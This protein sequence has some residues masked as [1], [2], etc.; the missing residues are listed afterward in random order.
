MNAARFRSLA[1]GDLK[2]QSYHREPPSGI[3]VGGYQEVEAETQDDQ[4][5][6]NGHEFH[7]LMFDHFSAVG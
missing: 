2:G 3:E 7:V 1:G 6:S 5:G 4:D